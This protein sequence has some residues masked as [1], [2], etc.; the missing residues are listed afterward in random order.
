[1]TTFCKGIWQHTLSVNMKMAYDPVFLLL[2]IHPAEI[3]AQGQS[4]SALAFSP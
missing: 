3:L 1:M 4:F 2:G